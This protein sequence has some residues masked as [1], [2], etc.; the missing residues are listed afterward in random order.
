MHKCS[1]RQIF[2]DITNT[3]LQFSETAKGLTFDVIKKF[4]NKMNS[5]EIAIKE[6]YVHRESF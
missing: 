4:R 6:R 2:F 5:K 1:K 3:Y